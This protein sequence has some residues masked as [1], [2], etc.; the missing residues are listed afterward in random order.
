MPEKRPNLV[1][2]VGDISFI[3]LRRENSIPLMATVDTADLELLKPFTWNYSKGYAVT[4]IWNGGRKNRITIAM[5]RMVMAAGDNDEVDHFDQDRLN[6]RK[7][8]LRIVPHYINQRNRPTRNRGVYWWKPRGRYR[9]LFKVNGKQRLFGVFK[10]YESA[11]K[12]AD[13][14]LPRYIMGDDLGHNPSGSSN[15]TETL[16]AATKEVIPAV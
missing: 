7:A 1:T 6:N 5:H 14:L 16:P 3:E 15:H 4:Y 13:E 11:R 9:V 2:T 10:D 12:R 8:N